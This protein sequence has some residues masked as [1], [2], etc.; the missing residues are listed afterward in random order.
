MG[1]SQKTKKKKKDMSYNT[2]DLLGQLVPRAIIWHAVKQVS[3]FLFLLPDLGLTFPESTQWLL[4]FF[5][6]FSPSLL[7]SRT[8][9]GFSY[10]DG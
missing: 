1:G 2:Q 4:V 8:R 5:H 9:I 10:H 6:G 7:E 3:I